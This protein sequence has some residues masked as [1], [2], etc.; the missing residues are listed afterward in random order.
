MFN[1]F[2]FIFLCSP[3][4]NMYNFCKMYFTANKCTTTTTYISSSVGGNRAA[5]NQ[6]AYILKEGNHDKGRYMEPTNTI[7][8]NL[9]VRL[10]SL[11]VVIQIQ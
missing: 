11:L 10:S 8:L 2:M 5:Y 1:L 4:G 7:A 9:K 3:N 6:G